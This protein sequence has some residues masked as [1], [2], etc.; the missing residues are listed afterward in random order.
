MLSA[1]KR[2]PIA[3]PAEFEIEP[4]TADAEYQ[5]ALAELAA[6]NQRLAQ[7]T[8]REAHA[9]ARARGTPAARTNFDRAR[10][11]MKG[12]RIPG[13]QAAAEIAAC[14]E[15]AAILRRAII[16]Q[17]A[18]LASIRGDRSYD[19]ARRFLPQHHE[20]LRAILDGMLILDDAIS[21]IRACRARR[22]AAGYN[23]A[24]YALPEAI[25]FIAEQLGD[26]RNGATFAGAYRRWLESEGIIPEGSL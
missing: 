8:E 3:D 16:E 19:L 11:L 6:L 2:R 17:N 15:E 20:A 23:E 24:S 21:A 25:P 12:G 4:I 9:R 10:D 18:K 22:V 14:E 26:P 13:V 5:A 7:T 1:R